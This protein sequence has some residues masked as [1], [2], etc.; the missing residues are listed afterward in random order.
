MSRLD[1]A[2]LLPQKTRDQ[3]QRHLH[4]HGAALKKYRKQISQAYRQEILRL[5][6][7]FVTA[8]LQAHAEPLF[9][10]LEDYLLWMEWCSWCSLHLAPPLGLTTTQD[11]RRM[12]AAMV[13]YCGPRLLDDA[14]D[15]HMNYKKLHPTALDGLLRLFPDRPREMIH[16]QL[17]LIGN[18]LILQGINRLTRH[19]STANAQA[20]LRLCRSIAPGAILEGLHL[21]PLNWTEYGE[22]VRRKS[23]RY[24]QIL[25]RNLLTPIAAREKER[26]LNVAA[27]LSTLAQYLN[28]FRDK[29]EDE[30]HGRDNLITWFPG[31]DAFHTLCQNQIHACL[32]AIE[33]LPT[34]T[35][36]ALAAALVETIEAAARIPDQ[37]TPDDHAKPI[38][39]ESHH[40]R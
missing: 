9:N 13:I 4:N 35:S 24:D 40:D 19:S 25:Y 12:A 11:A 6:M 16:S 15:S 7:D 22:I 8:P 39:G 31:E 3:A 18:W 32:D 17:C 21:R 1:A 26:L 30:H 29:R 37:T 14:I 27:H 33:S 5:R 34:A 38:A 10:I 28:D 2:T 36:D 23:V 20:T